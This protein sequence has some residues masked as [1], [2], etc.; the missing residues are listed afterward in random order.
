MCRIPLCNLV[1]IVGGYMPSFPKKKIWEKS[2]EVNLSPQSDDFIRNI[3]F[4]HWI[5]YFWD[6]EVC[7]DLYAK[8]LKGN[9]KIPETWHYKWE[10]R[11]FEETNIKTGEGTAECKPNIISSGVAVLD[12]RCAIPLDYLL[13][14]KHYSLYVTFSKYDKNPARELLATFTIKDRDE[15]KSQFLIGFILIVLTIILARFT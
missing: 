2:Y 10:L 8:S 7:F 13:P 15:L 1:P 5:P 9:I 4:F 14:N 11:G 3:D 6:K 12:K